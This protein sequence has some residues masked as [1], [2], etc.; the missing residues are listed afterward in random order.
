MIRLASAG[1]KKDVMKRLA[2][3]YDIDEIRVFAS[4]RWAIY[5]LSMPETLSA[6]DGAERRCLA[7]GLTKGM[8]I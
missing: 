8:I 6:S 5:L 7:N 2:D 4:L 1:D 3:N